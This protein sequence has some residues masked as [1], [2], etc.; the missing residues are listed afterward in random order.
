MGGKRKKGNLMSSSHSPSSSERMFLESDTMVATLASPP[1]T[2]PNHDS[3]YAASNVDEPMV[4]VSPAPGSPHSRQNHNHTDLKSIKGLNRNCSMDDEVSGTGESVYRKGTT[5]SVRT[6]S[7][8]ELSESKK[9]RKG[10]QGNR[11]TIYKV[12]KASRKKREKTSLFCP[13]AFSVFIK[14]GYKQSVFKLDST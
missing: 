12:N 7:E 1:M 9:E 8:D 10:T 5:A 13:A 3:G 6:A 4:P 14:S 2:D 11:F